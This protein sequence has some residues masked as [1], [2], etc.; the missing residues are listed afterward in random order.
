MFI[1]MFTLVTCCHDAHGQDDEYIRPGGSVIAAHTDLLRLTG[2]T[3]TLA[4]SFA[5]K[6]TVN[7]T[8]DSNINTE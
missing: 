1:A 3:T 4:H 8:C 5:L 7:Q 6:Y 2:L